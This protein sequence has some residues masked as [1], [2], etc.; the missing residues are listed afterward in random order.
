MAAQQPGCIAVW[1]SATGAESDD[2]IQ[3]PM[4][5]KSFL[6]RLHVARCAARALQFHA[7]DH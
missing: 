6:V 2:S 4:S 7:A 1:L 3:T 5:L